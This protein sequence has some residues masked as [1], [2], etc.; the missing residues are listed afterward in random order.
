MR[1]YPLSDPPPLPEAR[2]DTLCCWTIDLTAVTPIYRGGARQDKVDT[3]RPFRGSS[4]RGLLRFWWRATSPLQDTDELRSAEGRL[5][6]A[7][8]QERAIASR[9]RVGVTG[10]SSTEAR[11]PP[12]AEYALWVQRD[13]AQEVFHHDARCTLEVSVPAED[14]PEL[15][16]ALSAWLLFGGIGGRTRRGLGAVSASHP[17]L[18]PDLPDPSSLVTRATKLAL[19]RARAPWPS[20]SGGTLL[21]GPPSDDPMEAWRTG[22]RAMRAVRMDTSH[23]QERPIRLGF[24]P[25]RWRDDD[26]IKFTAGRSFRS[27]RAAL[28]LPLLF[29][30]WDDKRRRTMRLE[31]HDRFPSPIHLRPIQLG[32]CWHPVMTILSTPFPREVSADRV[33]GMLDPSGLGLFAADVAR[34]PGWTQHAIGGAP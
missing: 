10:G 9:V 2:P 14:A 21:I 31:G 3:S 8:F 34:I 30:S 20:L 33:R 32:S 29:Q 5:F 4:I 28:G 19:S 27:P 24:T 26:Y 15:R 12:G 7:V 17:K 22:L 11:K 16:R 1:S 25:H 18:T 6:G 23:G 13:G